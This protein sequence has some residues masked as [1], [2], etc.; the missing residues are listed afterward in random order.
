LEPETVTKEQ[1]FSRVHAVCVYLRDKPCKLCPANETSE[2]GHMVRGCYAMASEVQNIV[3]FGNP[4]GSS[5][6]ELNIR[7]YQEHFNDE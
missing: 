4:W 2:Y 6:S 5:A 3:T 1:K 7:R